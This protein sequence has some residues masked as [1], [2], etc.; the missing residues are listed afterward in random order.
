MEGRGRGGKR[1]QARMSVQSR[2]LYNSTVLI[3]THQVC[4]TLQKDV[5]D[6]G[7][8]VGTGVREGCVSSVG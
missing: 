7:V 5:G 4:S 2:V 8:T 6:Q 1:D 3:N